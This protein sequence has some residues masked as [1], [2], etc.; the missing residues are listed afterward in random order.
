[1]MT[2]GT[3]FVC[4]CPCVSSGILPDALRTEC[5]KCSDQQR[6]G[7][8]RVLR[9]IIDNKPTEWGILQRRYDPQNVYI[10]QASRLGVRV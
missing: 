5:S 6:R 10:S 1:M 4:V 2:S 3:H 8:E 7:S 9:Y